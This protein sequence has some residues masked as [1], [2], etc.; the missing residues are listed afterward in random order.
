[1][2]ETSLQEQIT[3]TTNS[4]PVNVEVDTSVQYTL[5]C[6]TSENVTHLTRTVQERLILW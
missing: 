2:D 4:T 3:A 5:Y 1:M 6:G